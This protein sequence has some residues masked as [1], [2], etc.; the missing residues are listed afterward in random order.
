MIKNRQYLSMAEVQEFLDLKSDHGKEMSLFIKKFTKLT[1]KEA[2]ELRKK[3]EELNMAKMKEE[4]VV[5]IIDVLP[6]SVQELNKVF[7]GAS[8]EENESNKILETVK[9]YK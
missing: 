4:Y 5:K 8:L 6:D 3:L 1:A 2:K 7:Q 9:Q